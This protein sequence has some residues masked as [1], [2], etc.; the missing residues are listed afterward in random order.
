MSLGFKSLTA[1]PASC[2]L[3]GK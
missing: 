1:D 3:H 2:T